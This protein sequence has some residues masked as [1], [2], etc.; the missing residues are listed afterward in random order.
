[1]TRTKTR[2]ARAYVWLTPLEKETWNAKA[3]S[4]GLNLNEY[5]RSCVER[6]KIATAPPEINRMTAV[7]LSRIGVNL[8]QQVRAM[9]TALASGQHISNIDEALATVSEVIL[10]VQKLQLDLIGAS[11]DRQ[12]C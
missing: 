3:A 1:M 5:I 6:R 12:D 9:N 7:E 8:N 11:H 2:T 10:T 4:A